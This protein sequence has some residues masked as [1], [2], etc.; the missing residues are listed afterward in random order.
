[1]ILIHI[2]TLRI[3]LHED[4]RRLNSLDQL[5]KNRVQPLE[6]NRC[7]TPQRGVETIG[8]LGILA[9]G[10]EGVEISTAAEGVHL[11]FA[12]LIAQSKRLTGPERIMLHSC[13]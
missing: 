10:Q 6:L 7:L 11:R 3:D 4:A 5:R 13:L 1:M 12:I 2:V 9:Q 8:L